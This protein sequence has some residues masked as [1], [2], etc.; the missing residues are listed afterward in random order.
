VEQNV[1]HKVGFFMNF[2][3]TGGVW[4]K[5]TI[6]DAG[7][8]QH[9]TITED[10]DLSYRAQLRGWKFVFL[11]DVTSPA[12]L[13]AEINAL[14]SQQFRWTKGAIEVAKKILPTVWKS[15][16]PFEVKLQSTVHLGANIVFPFIILVALLNVPLMII[17]HTSGGVYDWYFTLMG[18]FTISSVSTFAFYSCAQYAVHEKDWTKR[19]ILF[20]IF[21]AG[22][23]GLAINNTRAVIEALFNKKSEF[24]RTPKFK[25]EDKKD[26]WK[27]NKYKSRKIHPS[28]FIELA[29]AAYFFV[30]ICI[31]IAF[32]EISAIGF[33]F[34][35]FA[36]FGL[37][38]GLSVRHALS[39]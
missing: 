16:L 23:M 28:V 20:P 17:K 31:S 33:Q 32:L 6:I 14:K 25:V 36:G 13:P 18:F 29:F 34:M 30:G 22:S 11:N 15:D 7:N 27:T 5:S 12:E 24:V 35:F 8:W 19:I 3:G 4:R 10:M 38:G 39:R 2:N 37:M 26:S 1:R 9:D 21:M